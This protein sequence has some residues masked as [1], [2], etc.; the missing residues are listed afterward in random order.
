M[1]LC[2]RCRDTHSLARARTHARA[3]GRRRRRPLRARALHLLLPPHLTSPQRTHTHPAQT[4]I[5]TL[6]PLP[7]KS[8]I[9]LC[10]VREAFASAAL[11]RRKLKAQLCLVAA[12]RGGTGSKKTA[13]CVTQVCCALFKLK[14]RGRF[15]KSLSID[16]V[17]RAASPPG[18]TFSLRAC[19]C[20][21][22][23]CCVQ[24]CACVVRRR[25]RQPRCKATKSFA[26]RPKAAAQQQ[27]HEHKLRAPGPQHPLPPPVLSRPQKPPHAAPKNENVMN[28]T[29]THM[30][31]GFTSGRNAG[32]HQ[33][34]PFVF[35]APGSMRKRA[36][37]LMPSSALKK[38]SSRTQ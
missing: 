37:L 33:P 29:H 35:S 8:K 5:T 16:V 31:K 21:I 27:T 23:C 20:E 19:K 24:L 7:T 25:Q 30:C 38:K 9:G 26:A 18:N 22:C 17:R 1:D 36:I 15:P 28:T 13:R 2:V 3:S 6:A 14:Q 34:N 10:F 32:P 4:C 11:E 12:A